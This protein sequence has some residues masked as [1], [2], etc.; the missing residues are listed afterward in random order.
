[1]KKLLISI[2]ALFAFL[3]L[4]VKADNK[5][6]VYIFEAGG[7][8]Y[9]EEEITYLE[10]LDSYN[11]K[12]EIVRKELYIDHID[13]KKGSD[14]D[15]GVRVANGFKKVGF[16]DASYQGTPFVVISDIYAAT[17]YNTS[18]EDIINEA[19]DKGDKDIVKCYE[20]GKDNC[21]NHLN[22]SNTS[23][24]NSNASIWGIIVCTII[25]L[26]TYIYKS[27][28]DKETILKALNSKKEEKETN[29]K[30]KQN[31]KNK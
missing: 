8:P 5:V 15:L 19:Y 6:K 12:F 26:S 9:C 23:S 28:K 16:E 27:N 17:G 13:W 24:S 21:L 11:K 14:Y 30:E 29:T 18:L 4:I 1:M 10:G 2:L 31:N 25:I 3:P 20:D 7:C 22:T